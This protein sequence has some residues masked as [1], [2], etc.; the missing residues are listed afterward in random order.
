[1]HTI[2]F[3]NEPTEENPFLIVKKEAN[4]PCAPLTENDKNNAFFYAAQKF[5]QILNVSGKKSIEHGL[6]HRLDTVTEGIFLIALTQDFYDYIQNEQKNGRFTKIY[7]AKCEFL[8]ENTK[9]IEGFP[10]NDFKISEDFIISSYFRNFGPGA[11]EVRPVFENSSKIALKK[12]GKQKLYS[13]EVKILSK[14]QNEYFVECK[15]KEGYRHQVRCHLA[16]VNLPIKGDK[17]YNFNERQNPQNE[18]IEF[19][20]TGLE[21]IHPK[22]EKKV[23]FKWK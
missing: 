16:S 11:K 9:K 17:I 4:F 14:N 3:L 12:I 21:F 2:E 22:T 15:I 20:A 10:E 1:M 18:K 7:Q 5:P 6:V 23:L 19:L 8:K 13:T